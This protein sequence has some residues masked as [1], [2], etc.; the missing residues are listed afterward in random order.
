MPVTATLR[1]L[2]DLITGNRSFWWLVLI[3]NLIGSAYGFWWYRDQ[4]LSSPWYL[5]P[6]IPDSP[7]SSFLFSCWLFAMIRGKNPRWLGALAFISL[8]KYGFWTAIVLPQ[9]AIWSGHWTFEHVHLSLS[10]LSMAV[11]ALLFS[12]R[13][14]VGVAWAAVA[15]GWMY[16]QDFCDY[17]WLGTHPTLPDDALLRS[18][19][20]IALGL[21]TVWGVYL[22][23]TNRTRVAPHG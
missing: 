1:R 6:I 23:Y 18:A 11:E 9:H 21:S 12:Q 13:Y 4:L 22:L 3:I 17:V 8:L 5:W 10:H 2:Y 7:G 15:L 16:F 20:L 19:G 14:K